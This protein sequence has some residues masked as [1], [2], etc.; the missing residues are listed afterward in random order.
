MTQFTTPIYQLPYCDDDE[1]A[2]QWP[3]IQAKVSKRIEQAFIDAQIPPGDPSQNAVVARL[4]ALEE[5]TKTRR[6]EFFNSGFDT[7]AGADWDIGPQTLDTSA[8]ENNDFVK[9]GSLSGSIELTASGRFRV[10]CMVLSRNNPGDKFWLIR[11]DGA[12]V[13]ADGGNNALWETNP[14]AMSFTGT[15]GKLIRVTGRTANAVRITSRLVIE[16][17]S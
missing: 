17:I 12:T 2:N 5:K 13:G 14:V 6:A 1:P 10:S 15:A 3:G 16:K 4:N 7:G 11:N 8:S 9:V